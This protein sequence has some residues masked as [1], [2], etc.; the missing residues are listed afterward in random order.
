MT[1]K[2]VCSNCKQQKEQGAPPD[3]MF[4]LHHDAERNELESD[5]YDSCC[6]K[7]VRI[8]KEHNAPIEAIIH[9]KSVQR[10]E[11]KKKGEAA[12]A[13][14]SREIKAKPKPQEQSQSLPPAEQTKPDPMALLAG[15]IASLADAQKAT[16]EK[17]D[18]LLTG[19]ESDGKRET[20]RGPV[21]S[22]GRRQNAPAGAGNQRRPA[23]NEGSGKLR[24]Q[25]KPRR[26][27]ANNNE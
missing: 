21:E 27:K 9:D 22:G 24:K 14:Q 11:A 18:R 10:K 4:A 5:K 19:K 17:L 3:L 25:A 2:F 13:V 23:E 1:Y 7:C 20:I 16:N 26:N 6:S 12:K 15:A 8:I